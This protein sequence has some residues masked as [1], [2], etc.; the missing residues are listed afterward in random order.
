[1]RRSVLPIAAV[2]AAELALSL[3]LAGCGD[4]EADQRRAFITFLQTRILDKPGIHVP[5]LTDEE[6]RAF[7]P[8]AGQYAIITTFHAVM[9]D[10]VSPQFAAVMNRGAIRSMDDLVARRDDLQQAR[11]TLAGLSAALKGDVAQADAAHGKLDQPADLRPVFD[12]AYGRLVTEAAANFA[13]VTPAAD[14]MFAQALDLGGYLQSHH[15][16]LVGGTLQVR[17]AATQAA[18]NAKLQS[19]QASQQA[20]QAAASR[21]R[22]FVYGP[23]S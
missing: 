4:G 8:Y 18:V 9:N 5:Q 10:S 20:T 21:F 12:K 17:D 1:M 23:G 11:S 14:Q 6:R 7:G 19:L 2:L 16:A 3:A 22:T 15:V 13:A